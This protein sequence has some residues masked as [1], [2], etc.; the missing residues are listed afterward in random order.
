MHKKLDVCTKVLEESVANQKAS[1]R[2]IMEVPRSDTALKD[3]L[4]QC[5]ADVFHTQ[6]KM[7]GIEDAVAII[8]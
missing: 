2:Q 7:G 3:R 1:F 6:N 5:Q 4:E 8:P